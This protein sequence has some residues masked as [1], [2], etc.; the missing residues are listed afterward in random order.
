[1]PENSIVAIIP[2]RY[3]SS[4]LPYKILHKLDGKSMLH[5]VFE[6]ASQARGIDDV[7]IATDHQL[8]LKEAERFGATAIM[9]SADHQSGTDRIAEAAGKFPDAD[10]FVNVQGDQPF[11]EPGMIEKLIEPYRQGLEPD[12]A[13]VACPLDQQEIS[14]PNMVKVAVNRKNIAMFFTR[15]PIPYFRNPVE[16]LPVYQHVGLYAYSAAALQ[17]ISGLDA[18]KLELAEG[19]EQMRALEEGLSIY[20]STYEQMVPEINTLE[21]LEKAQEMGLIDNYT[22]FKEE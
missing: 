15:S 22:L 18:S 9:T 6:R 13:T 20:V 14:N 1:V 8:I 10:V 16:N 2:A 11:L 3:Q 19:L 17:K 7:V 12:M 21:D 4:R 5:W